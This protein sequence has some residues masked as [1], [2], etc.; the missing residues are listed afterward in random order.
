[1]ETGREGQVSQ[2][3]AKVENRT[4]RGRKENH[5]GGK[6]STPKKKGIRSR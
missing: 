4:C 5:Q 3:L 6:E 2:S 1:V